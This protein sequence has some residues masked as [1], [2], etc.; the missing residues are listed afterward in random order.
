MK[1]KKSLCVALGLVMGLPMAAGCAPEREE[2]GNG[3][4]GGTS[5]NVAFTDVWSDGM[6]ENFS[7]GGDFSSSRERYSFSPAISEIN[8]FRISPLSQSKRFS[9][10][11]VTPYFS[12]CGRSRSKNLRLKSSSS[13]QRSLFP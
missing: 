8:I 10:H 7:A 12:R 9:R 3:G 2:N 6:A 1:F 11:S 4:N 13:F 5:E